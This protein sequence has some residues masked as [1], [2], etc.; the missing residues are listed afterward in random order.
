MVGETTRQALVQA[1]PE[2]MDRV[3]SL[4]AG[5]QLGTLHTRFKNPDCQYGAAIVFPVGDFF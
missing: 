2:G 1:L 5:G 3:L 4:H